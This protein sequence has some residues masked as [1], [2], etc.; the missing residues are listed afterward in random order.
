MF[1]LGI[2]ESF[3]TGGTPFE[4]NGFDTFDERRVEPPESDEV[5]CIPRCCSNAT[6]GKRFLDT[7]YRQ[8]HIKDDSKYNCCPKCRRVMLLHGLE[9]LRELKK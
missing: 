6:C 7:P 2:P 9:A 4:S 5:P 3:D 1:D 8:A